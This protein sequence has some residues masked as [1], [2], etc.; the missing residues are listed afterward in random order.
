MGVVFI[1]FAGEA[2]VNL[3]NHIYAVQGIRMPGLIMSNNF[4]FD[5][6]EKEK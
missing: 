1:N 5:L 4:L 2:E 6:P 3:N